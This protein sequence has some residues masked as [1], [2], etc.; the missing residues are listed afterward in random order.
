M[1]GHKHFRV[2]KYIH[3]A[4]H[5]PN[6]HPSAAPPPF[7]LPSPHPKKWNSSSKLKTGWHQTELEALQNWTDNNECISVPRQRGTFS[8]ASSPGPHWCW[9]CF[10]RTIASNLWI[11]LGRTQDPREH[12]WR[13]TTGEEFRRKEPSL[14]RKHSTT[15]VLRF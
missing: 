3:T 7:P 1:I 13:T 5:Q 10:P 14:R 2:P 8:R 9:Q 15:G 12:V 6:L 11:D 4:K